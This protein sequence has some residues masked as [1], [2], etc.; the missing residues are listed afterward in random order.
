MITGTTENSRLNELKKYKITNVF[1]EQYFGNGSFT[2]DGVDFDTSISGITI[3]YY[4][5]G[6]KYIDNVIE[7]LTIFQYEQQDTEMTNNF[8]YKDP[9]K[10]NVVSNTKINDDVF[11]DRQILTAFDLNYKLEFVKSFVDLNTYVG[12]K[13]FNVIKNV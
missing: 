1:S 3:T 13:Y 12:G 6:I 11:I 2:T 4:I 7:S 8:I 10:E 5:G 9:N